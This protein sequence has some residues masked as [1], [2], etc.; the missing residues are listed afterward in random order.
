M[1]GENE[2][3]KKEGKGGKGKGIGRGRGRKRVKWGSISKYNNKKITNLTNKQQCKDFIEK[4][5]KEIQFA[6]TRM[7]TTIFISKGNYYL[8]DKREMTTGRPL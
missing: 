5:T 7:V 6:R 8:Q 4:I 3:E 2:G 1:K